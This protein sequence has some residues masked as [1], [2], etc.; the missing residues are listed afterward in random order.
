[1][2]PAKERYKKGKY[3]YSYFYLKCSPSVL[4]L[5][6]NHLTVCNYSET[7]IP[8]NKKRPIL[9]IKDKDKT[10]SSPLIKLLP[11]LLETLRNEK[12]L[13]AVSRGTPESTRNS[14]GQNTFDPDLTQDYNSQVSQEI[15]GRVTKKTLKRI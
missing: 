7:L 14:R 4:Y 6:I 1:M 13:A 9:F 5:S 12:K 11:S 15:E 2:F 3:K 10:Q 8:H